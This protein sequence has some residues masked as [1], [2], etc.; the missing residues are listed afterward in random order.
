MLEVAVY[1]HTF[2][3]SCALAKVR[4]VGT[5]LDHRDLDAELSDLLG[6]SLVQRLGSGFG[7]GVE[8]DQGHRCETETACYTKDVP[9]SLL[10]EERQGCSQDADNA[11]VVRLE[12]I[13]HLLVGRFFGCRD[14]AV[15]GIV[16]KHIQAT[17][18]LECLVDDLCHP[19]TVGYIELQRQD[20]VSESLSK[21]GNVPQFAGDR[22]HL[23]SALER[24]LSPDASETA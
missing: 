3:S 20:Q 10:P 1:L 8:A 2:C 16:H 14:Q 18:M 5:G 6:Q 9:A 19:F 4:G 11:E 24:G 12:D 21:I 13:L 7:C 17:K 23:V 15:P 22:S